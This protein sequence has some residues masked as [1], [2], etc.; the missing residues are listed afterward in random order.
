MENKVK[1]YVEL[2]IAEQIIKDSKDF[3]LNLNA[4]LNRIVKALYNKINIK[5]TF[6]KTNS[7][8]ALVF[9]LNKENSVFLDLDSIINKE[10]RIKSDF[11]RDILY[12]YSL[13][14]PKKR[15]EIIFKENMNFIQYAIKNKEICKVLFH[16]EIR[17][18]EPYSVLI[19]PDDKF[20]YLVCYDYKAGDL[21]CFKFYSIKEIKINNEKFIF[22]E[23]YRKQVI[24]IEENFDP[25]LSYGH[26]LK[27]KFTHKGM[28]KLERSPHNRPL[29]IN[30]EENIYTF[31]C[32]EFNALIYFPPFFG[33]I[34]ILEPLE[35]RN[36]FVESLKNTLCLYKI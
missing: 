21:R 15:A 12:T 33:E 18:I 9:N 35:V 2:H 30:K 25:F 34:E 26:I 6:D 16:K 23:K 19:N 7:N 17:I 13:L 22:Y 11:F 31:Y 5:S 24:G 28:E 8:K 29:L 1:V 10:Y 20:Y 3:E 4:L 32:K 36:A 14:S 27:V